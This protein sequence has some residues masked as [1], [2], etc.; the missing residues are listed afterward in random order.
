VQN[1]RELLAHARAHP[2]KLSFASIGVGSTGH[3]AF[4]VLKNLNNLFIVHIPYKSTGETTRAVLS[5]ETDIGIDP[6]TSVGPLADAGK[7]RVLAV[8]S[9]KRHPV[10]PN[11]PG[12]EESGIRNYDFFTWVGLSAPA[13]TPVPVI[14]KLNAT[15]NEVLKEPEMK[16]R[17]ERGG[18]QVRG[19]TPDEFGRYI[20]REVQV[21]RKVIAQGKFDFEQ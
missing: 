9:Q 11:V 14:Q 10:S 2:G 17:L 12:M 6:F 8:A 13:S 4:E 15:L 3:L 7:L 18:Y 16:T 19:G 21:W 1:V 20:S 5:G